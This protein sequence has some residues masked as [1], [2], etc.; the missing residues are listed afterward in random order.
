VASLQYQH[1]F[2]AGDLG[3]FTFT[4][5][6]TI[7]SSY[8]TDF[9]N[10]QDGRQGS[11]TQ[12]GASLEFRPTGDRFS[13]LAFVRNIENTRALS[14]GGLTNAGPDDIFNWQFSAPRTYGIRLGFEY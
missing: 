1:E 9:F 4:A 5:D 8:F 3:S 14:F 11:T 12:S 7:K 10:R 13:I 2:D 6:T